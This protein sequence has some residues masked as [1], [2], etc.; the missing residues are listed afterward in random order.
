MS[1]FGIRFQAQGAPAAPNLVDDGQ[2]WP[3]YE[4]AEIEGGR[5]LAAGIWHSFTIEKRY[6]GR[7]QPRGDVERMPKVPDAGG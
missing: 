1:T 4:E 5:Y 2:L 3:T 6:H 7:P